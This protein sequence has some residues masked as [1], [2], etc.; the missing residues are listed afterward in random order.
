MFL[1]VRGHVA[2]YPLIVLVL[3]LAIHISDLR[4]CL[5]RIWSHLETSLEQTSCVFSM[6]ADRWDWD[7]DELQD[8]LYHA[9][10]REKQGENYSS[11][12]GR[13]S[14][15]LRRSRTLPLIFGL[16]FII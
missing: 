8:R 1:R 9:R 10:E 13:F 11:S 6:S 15:P 2:R 4:E 14:W 5:C 16:L 12:G 7:N 3:Y